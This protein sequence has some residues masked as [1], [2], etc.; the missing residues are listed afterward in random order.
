MTERLDDAGRATA[1][2]RLEALH[3]QALADRGLGHDQ[4]I[5]VEIVVVLGVGDGRVQSLPD[6]L[7]DALLGEGELVD[8]RRRLLAADG[9]GHEVE[10]AWADAD[11]AQHGLG[12]VVRLAAG[13]GWLAHRMLLLRH[14]LIARVAMEGAGRRELAELVSDHL[15]GDVHRDEFLAV[16]D[17]ERQ[18]DELRQD[19]RA[20]RPGPDHFAA[21]GLA[22]LLGLL[23]QA[24]LHEGTF[25][26]GT[27]HCPISSSARRATAAD[28]VLVRRLV[29]AGLLALGRLAP[30]RDRVAAARGAAFAAAVRMVD[31]VH[32]DAAVMR[33]PAQPTGTAGLADRDVHVIGVRHRT[34][35]AA[36]TAVHQ[37]LFARVQAQNDVILIAADDLRIG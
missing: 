13:S 12:L 19:R 33:T 17:A 2:A 14:L 37:A 30:R 4:A 6:V 15:L 25:P 16:V 1:A 18:P 8:G 32:D 22:R 10:L 35:G 26:N 9:G 3:H 29:L 27:C 36:A 11:G 28:D 20:P 31:R 21:H 5:D 23:D 24:A 7:G 34:D